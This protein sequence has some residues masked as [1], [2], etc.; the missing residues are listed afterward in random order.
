MTESNSRRS[1]EFVIMLLLNEVNYDVEDILGHI[2]YAHV[3]LGGNQWFGRLPIIVTNAHFTG[4][5]L[6]LLD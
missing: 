2:A 5:R 3:R 4:S 1:N 6:C